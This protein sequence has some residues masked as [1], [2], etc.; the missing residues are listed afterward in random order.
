MR[1]T[2][3]YLDP[4]RTTTKPAMRKMAAIEYNRSGDSS[5]MVAS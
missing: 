3:A 1:I 5:I 4:T 2:A